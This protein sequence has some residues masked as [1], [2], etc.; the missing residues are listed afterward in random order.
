MTLKIQKVIAGEAHRHR[1][2]M[3]KN[4]GIPNPDYRYP[5]E[6]MQRQPQGNPRIVR[7]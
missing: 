4:K 5:K 1:P 7:S 2:N 6:Y 3:P